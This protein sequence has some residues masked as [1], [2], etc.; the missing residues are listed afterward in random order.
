MDKHPFQPPEE[1]KVWIGFLEFSA[2]VLDLEGGREA[3]LS[4]TIHKHS[5]RDLFFFFSSVF[6]WLVNTFM[7]VERQ[8]QKWRPD[9]CFTCFMGVK[10]YC[11]GSSENLPSP[12]VQHR[13]VGLQPT[14]LVVASQFLTFLRKQQCPWGPVWWQ[15]PTALPIVSLAS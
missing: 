12:R 3:A 8:V 15:C 6:Q 14:V 9:Q 13:G 2:L 4:T 7:G 5:C 10:E 11:R 1:G